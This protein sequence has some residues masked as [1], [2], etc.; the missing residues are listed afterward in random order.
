M[1]VV[2]YRSVGAGAKKPMLIPD[3]K[4]VDDEANFTFTK[5][6]P[7]RYYLMAWDSAPPR[8]ERQAGK[9]ADESFSPTYYPN[10][11]RRDG[12]TPLHICRQRGS[13][14]RNSPAEGP[15][16]SRSRKN[17]EPWGRVSLRVHL[18]PKTPTHLTPGREPQGFA[19]ARSSSPQSSRDLTSLRRTPISAIGSRRPARSAPAL[20][21]CS[22]GARSKSVHGILTI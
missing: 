6:K 18:R 1:Q 12:A 20:R 19:M 16:G 7:G 15:G 21:R 9:D 8:R 3:F 5:L 13:K 10:G 11:R 2:C 22:P 4:E 14:R 17:R